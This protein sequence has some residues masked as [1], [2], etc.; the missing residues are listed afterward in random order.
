MTPAVPYSAFFLQA[1]RFVLALE[2]FWSND[3][4]D[5]GGATK[6][7]ISLRF[8]QRLPDRDRDGRPDGD[9]DGDGDVDIDDVRFVTEARALQLYHDEF[10]APCQC[11]ALPRPF[12]VA[13][14]CAAVNHGRRAAVKLF[15]EALGGLRIDGDVGERTLAAA[16]AADPAQALP[17]FLSRRAQFY[18]DI[19]LADASQAK[20]LRGW[21]RRLFLLQHFILSTPAPRPRG[22]DILTEVR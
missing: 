22:G 14:F 11:D 17:D 18:R 7:G 10:W 5:R 8:L 19:V 21:F 13:V 15:Q 12:A 9:L 3:P 6:Y 2:G 16:L 1:A 4:T 20:Y